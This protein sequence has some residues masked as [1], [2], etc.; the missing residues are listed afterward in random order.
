ME[1]F[2]SP[3]IIKDVGFGGA[4]G[5]LAGFVLKRVF[6]ML[7]FILGLYILGLMWL[8]NV[9]LVEVKWGEMEEFVRGFFSSFEGLIASVVRS[10][11]FGGSFAIG[12]AIGLKV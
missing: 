6:K 7:L 11:P 2:L 9:G 4:L 5:F 3:E 8:A 10:V 12:F 1:G